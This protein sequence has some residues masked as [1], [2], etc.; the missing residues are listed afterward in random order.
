MA[1]KVVEFSAPPKQFPLGE[2]WVFAGSNPS[3]PVW[4]S[5]VLPVIVGV[6]F[7]NVCVI[8]RM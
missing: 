8:V 3:L 2:F 7:V 4:S 1:L 6:L 5:H